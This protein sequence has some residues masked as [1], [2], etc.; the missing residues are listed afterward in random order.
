MARIPPPPEQTLAHFRESGWMRV[1]GAFDAAAAA[2]M[3]EVVWRA[4]ADTGIRSDDASTWNVER[5]ANLQHARD[6]PAFRAVGSTALYAVIDQ[7]MEGRPYERP[8]NFGAL[9]LAFPSRKPWVVPASGWHIDANYLS[10]LWPPRGVKIF[11]L[12]GDA[13][14]HGGST[15][16]LSGSHRLVHQW[17][18]EN[19][20]PAA[21]RSAQMRKLMQ[22]HPYIRD[23]H[24]SG[25]EAE[26][27]TRFM[28][29][30]TAMDGISLRVVEA[31][32]AAGDVILAHPLT[33]H[34]ASNNAAR[35]PRMM[36]S[37][38]ITTDMWGWEPKSEGLAGPMHRRRG[39]R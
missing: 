3:R 37:G 14:P 24:G 8:R 2:R 9:F 23:L 28:H 34:V 25:D 30:D 38:G 17:F 31:T 1:A 7:I 32:G 21:A 29:S 4:L 36:L 39:L 6:D 26:R 19:P 15:L 22:Q 35:H 27:I 33:L 5:P 10:P 12:L 20:P 13:G 16:M 18:V 11:A